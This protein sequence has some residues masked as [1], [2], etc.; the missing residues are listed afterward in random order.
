MLRVKAWS[1][2]GENRAVREDGREG[3]V[4]GERGEWGHEREGGAMRGEWHREGRERG[5]GR[6]G[7]VRG[8]WG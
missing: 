2:A 5:D 6:D 1:C 8:K 7:A 3:A 4:R